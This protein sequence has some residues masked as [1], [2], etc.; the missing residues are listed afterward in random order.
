MNNILEQG[1]TAV[2]DPQRVAAYLV[3]NQDEVA[4][5]TAR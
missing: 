3:S 1:K 2:S 4:I 5:A